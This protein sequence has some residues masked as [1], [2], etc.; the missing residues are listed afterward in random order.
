[1]QQEWA[2]YVWEAQYDV[3]LLIRTQFYQH[4]CIYPK[5]IG[6]VSTVSTGRRGN[7]ITLIHSLNSLKWNATTFQSCVI[8]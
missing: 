8:R 3:L 1:M 4:T 7:V 2:S 6:S 5:I